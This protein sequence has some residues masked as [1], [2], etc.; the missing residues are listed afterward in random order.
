MACVQDKD[1]VLQKLCFRKFF[2][3]FGQYQTGQHICFGVPAL[4]PAAC[5][6]GSEIGFEVIYSLIADPHLSV[7]DNRF[8][9]TQN[10]Q[11]PIAQRRAFFKGNTQKIPDDLDRNLACEIFD[12]IDPTFFGIS[13]CH[14]IQKTGYCI[15]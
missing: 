8:Q 11:G 1:A 2:C 10:G 12:N 13:L 7:T 9:R 4:L 3:I 5:D 14:I 15:P 6:K